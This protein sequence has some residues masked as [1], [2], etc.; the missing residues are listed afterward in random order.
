MELQNSFESSLLT[1]DS[2]QL[3]ANRGAIINIAGILLN[4]KLFLNLFLGNI[5]LFKI[6]TLS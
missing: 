5:L 3:A 6:F 4:V 2:L 1:S